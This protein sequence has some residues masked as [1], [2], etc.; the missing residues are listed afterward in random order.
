MNYHLRLLKIERIWEAD[1]V[2]YLVGIILILI[3]YYVFAAKFWEAAEAKGYDGSKYKWICFFFGLLGMIL[4]AALPDLTLH[5][6]IAELKNGPASRGEAGS[7]PAYIQQPSP[8]AQYT[9]YD[10]PTPARPAPGNG[11]ICSCGRSHPAYESSCA[12]GKSKH[13][14]GNATKSNPVNITKPAT[15]SGWTCSCGR[16]YPPYVTSC[17]CGK[18]KHDR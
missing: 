15:G 12:C 9:T 3:L 7:V 1:M 16:N 14:A 8:S 2:G 6:A 5:N 17:P 10:S 4:V 18:S 13:D 11:W